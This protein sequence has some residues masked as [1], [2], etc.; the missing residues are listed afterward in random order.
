M[1]RLAKSYFDD[2]P[3]LKDSVS[4]SIPS[5]VNYIEATAF[6]D[7]SNLQSVSFASPAAWSQTTIEF[8]AFSKQHLLGHDVLRNFVNTLG[9]H[10]DETTVRKH[11]AALGT[12]I[13][14]QD[15]KA[16]TSNVKRRC[17]NIFFV[18]NVSVL[19]TSLINN[20][21]MLRRL[22]VPRTITSC[23]P[24]TARNC[25]SLQEVVSVHR[26]EEQ[27]S[28]WHLCTVPVPQHRR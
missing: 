5:T 22:V 12:V 3:S 10:P 26:E 11:Y 20:C 24:A 9:P 13:V 16:L 27:R 2:N 25:P 28:V 15:T 4:F 21:V 23:W 6:D 7:L 8:G 17:V 14:S 1:S 18:S 19:P